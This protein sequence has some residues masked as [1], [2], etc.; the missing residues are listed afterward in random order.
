MRTLAPPERLSP[1]AAETFDQCPKKW[2]FKYVKG[3]EGAAGPEAMLGT[4]VHSVL[5]QLMELAGPERSMPAA[6]AIARE[7]WRDQGYE[8]QFSVFE[9]E[10]VDA[11][12]AAWAAIV[13]L[14]RIENPRD[15]EVVSTEDK[16]RTTIGG[17][18]FLGIVDLQHRDWLGGLVIRDWK[19]GKPPAPM[20]R[21]P[22]DRQVRLYAAAVEAETG[23]VP[24]GGQLVW[25]GK[26]PGIWEVDVD[27]IA[28]G[29]AVGWLRDLWDELNRSVG[30]DNF[31]ARPG[32]LCGWCPGVVACEEGKE[33]VLRQM[34]DGKLKKTAPAWSLLGDKGES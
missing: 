4:F 31:E 17:V 3:I 7:I 22:K 26:S 28:V 1:S 25:L 27:P 33:R 15:I 12:R 19:T 18:P 16:F 24:S 34:A 6:K 21:A 29:E 32:P 14:F 9:A 10:P 23:E 2:E 30:T 13:R 11:R 5:E 8:D 20:F